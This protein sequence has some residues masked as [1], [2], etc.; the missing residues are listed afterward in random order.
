MSSTIQHRDRIQKT[1]QSISIAAPTTGDLAGWR[2]LFNA[3]AAFYE[4]PMNDRIADTVWSWLQNQIHPVKAYLAK[5]ETGKAIGFIHYSELPR[6]LHGDCSLYID[7]LF[8][9]PHYR[10]SGVGTLLIDRVVKK[11]SE[12]NYLVVRWKTA[13]TNYKAR[14][15][16]DR[17]AQK[18]IWITYEINIAS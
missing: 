18:T 10:G 8:I 7:D 4:E 15:L 16:Y 12:Q 3:Y 6:P 9:D 14:T 2:S 11:A 5:D 13:E 1:R 17:L